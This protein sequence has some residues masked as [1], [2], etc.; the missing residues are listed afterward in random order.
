MADV[1]V[2]V[3]EARVEAFAEQVL[4]DW[5]AAAGVLMSYVGDRLACTAPWPARD[6]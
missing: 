5:S 6:C 2:T 1:E 4:A 3:D